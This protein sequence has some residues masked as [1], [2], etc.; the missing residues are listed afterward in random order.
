M[1]RIAT[2][3][4]KRGA[5]PKPK[6]SRKD[7][8]INTVASRRPTIKAR[9][10][11]HQWNL[12]KRCFL[13]LLFTEFERDPV[14]FAE[15]TQACFEDMRQ[16]E[17]N[18]TYKD[19]RDLWNARYLSSHSKQWWSIARPYNGILG[20]R[21]RNDVP[22]NM[23]ELAEWARLRAM[24]NR[25]AAGNGINL[26]L[27][28]PLN[29]ELHDPNGAFIAPATSSLAI[30]P[31]FF[32]PLARAATGIGP[33]R[34][35]TG[36]SSVPKK[37]SQRAPRKA[38]TISSS[39]AKQLKHQNA[40]P[41]NSPRE[42]RRASIPVYREDSDDEDE[43]GGDADSTKSDGEYA[44]DA[45]ENEGEQ[46]GEE[47]DAFYQDEG[48]YL[49]GHDDDEQWEEVVRFEDAQDFE[50]AE[51]DEVFYAA[52]ISEPGFDLRL[53]KEPRTRNTKQAPVHQRKPNFT[54]SSLPMVHHGALTT[55]EL[56]DG[57]TIL[58]AATSSRFGVGVPLREDDLEDADTAAYNDGG[59]ALRLY[60]PGTDLCPGHFADTMICNPERC[61]SAGCDAIEKAY[62][63]TAMDWASKPFV[64]LD[65][66]VS[67]SDGGPEFFPDSTL[68]P[69]FADVN[70]DYLLEI[71]VI[72]HNGFEQFTV[73]ALVCS[74]GDCRRCELRSRQEPA[75]T[76]DGMSEDPTHEA[77]EDD[78]GD[79]GDDEQEDQDD[80][81]NN[82]EPEYFFDE[83]D[84]GQPGEVI[85]WDDDMEFVGDYE[86]VLQSI[87]TADAGDEEERHDKR[88]LQSLPTSFG[89]PVLGD[90]AFAGFGEWLFT[91]HA[92]N[93]DRPRA[94]QDD[95]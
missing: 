30:S 5:A 4:S 53:V 66:T 82:R 14:A 75:D 36:A 42:R 59:A 46:D 50:E 90:M 9:R 35:K 85:D 8:H 12:E 65:D 29:K 63:F 21:P 87:E 44:Q 18:C 57:F 1:G 6:S 43:E 13:H 28:T 17:Y 60:Y 22:Y 94:F 56:D 62:T 78:E 89:M 19:L 76:T 34:S 2:S 52:P 16:M 91:N 72:F 55:V 71:D 24:I 83:Q 23:A 47:D 27:K 77:D 64:H 86:A 39:S 84:D 49:S 40:T 37:R 73:P 80:R 88:P 26:R 74:E 38:S 61:Q 48:L 68:G 70:P 93:S 69:T 7:T 41:A 15:L 95:E 20:V 10:G 54:P 32:A 3:S 51:D 92:S 79:E 58:S 11:I 81:R 31:T 33:P 45:G 25:V 67:T